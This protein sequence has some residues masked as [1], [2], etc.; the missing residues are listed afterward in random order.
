MTW[1]ACVAVALLAVAC[2]ED[3]PEQ[4]AAPAGASAT[5]EA[6]CENLSDIDC[7]PAPTTE[8]C[9]ETCQAA[10]SAVPDAERD[11]ALA[12]Y[13]SAESCADVEGCSRSCGAGGRPVGWVGV[14]AGNELPDAG[15]DA[16]SGG[17]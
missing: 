17:G 13:A 7:R 15:A 3:V 11:R 4:C 2:N 1:L 5:C 9:V 8:E 16:A 14:D 10:G 12:C 6:A